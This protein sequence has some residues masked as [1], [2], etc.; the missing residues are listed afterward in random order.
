MTD[1]AIDRDAG[2]RRS[3]D[4]AARLRALATG[5]RATHHGWF[6]APDDPPTLAE[7]QDRLTAHLARRL[8][9][10]PAGVLLDVGCGAGQP[11]LQLA[12]ETGCTV[13]GMDVRESAADEARTAAER[14]GLSGQASFH[15]LDVRRA[16]FPRGST[17][18]VLLLE[19]LADLGDAEPVL[20]ELH[21]A[22]RP[23]GHLVVA[24]LFD[25]P[26]A[27]GPEWY[28]RFAQV[29]TGAVPVALHELI[30]QLRRCGFGLVDVED[31]QER[32]APTSAARAA[33][34]EAE[35]DL[36]TA[37]SGAAAVADLRTAHRQLAE[38]VTGHMHYAVVTAVK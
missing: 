15:A 13:L 23:G 6:D 14:S 21:R 28:E 34:V 18:A 31:A 16:S 27:H 37:D 33:A 19:S 24:D 36:L 1:E 4:T 26:G 8:Q 20:A 5:S 32:T 9:I 22:L 2:A 29:R 7:A 11:A 3:S 25:D 17:D 10:G 12:A 30:G 38:V 35:A